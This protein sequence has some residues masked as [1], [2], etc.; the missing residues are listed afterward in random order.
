LTWIDAVPVQTLHN[1]AVYVTLQKR[2]AF[3][4]A[5]SGSLTPPENVP[6][7]QVVLRGTIEDPYHNAQFNLHVRYGIERYY[8]REGTGNPRGTLTVR[9]V[10]NPDHTPLI[11]QLYLNGQPYAEAMRDAAR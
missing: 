5:I 8:V 7:N 4:Q 10:V 9:C 11:K 2:G 3:H 6:P 1:R